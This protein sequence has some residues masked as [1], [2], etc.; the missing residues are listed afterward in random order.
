MSSKS[1]FSISR[2]LLPVTFLG[3]F[4]PGSVRAAADP[5]TALTGMRSTSLYDYKMRG[6]SSTSIRLSQSLWEGGATEARIA[7]Q[8]ARLSSSRHELADAAASLVFDAV[9]AHVD[10]LRQR[11]L[12]ELARQNVSDHKKIVAMLR[13]RVSSGLVTPGDVSLVESRLFRAEGTLEEYRSELLS[14]EANF[15]MVTGRP[16]PMRMAEVGLPTQLYASPRHVL[17]AC[18]LK[19]PRILA[20]QEAIH[21]A[22]GEM[23]LA[24]AGD[25]PK[26][27]VEVGPRWHVQDTPQDSTNHGW[28]AFVTFQWALYEGGSVQA[29][30]RGAAA[31]ER[32]ARQNMRHVADSLEADIMG[33]WARYEAAGERVFLYE[34]SMRSAHRA[35]SVFHEQYL[36]GSK[37]LLDLLDADDEYFLAASQHARAKGDRVIGAYRLL[38]L[39]GDILQA[40]HV[41]TAEAGRK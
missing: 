4:C 39:G 27:G 2:I 25:F 1:L 34:K 33:T 37:G 41:S 32:Q 6:L 22:R 16:V 31:R 38:A 3:L 5:L 36:L 9:T 13:S 20:E 26:I 30:K 23:S 29:A 12:V 40:L 18:R 11:T 15:Q 28:D 17:D 14:S 7:I 10:V 21:A 8:K 19:N 35:K 24:G